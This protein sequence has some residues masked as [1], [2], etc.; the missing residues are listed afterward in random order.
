MEPRGDSE[1]AL[2]TIPAG[3]GVW[4]VAGG[5]AAADAQA[6]SKVAWGPE[7]FEYLEQQEL[8]DLEDKTWRTRLGENELER[9]NADDPTEED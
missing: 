1:R 7:Y 3:A 5:S 9:D 6:Y 2:E 4:L 8:K